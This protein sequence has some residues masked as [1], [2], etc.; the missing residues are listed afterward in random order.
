MN[1]QQQ[2]PPSDGTET[3]TVDKKTRTYD[4]RTSS[5]KDTFILE[6][7]P[8]TH[9]PTPED[10]SARARKNNSKPRR[11]NETRR[12]DPTHK[13]KTVGTHSRIQP[14]YQTRNLHSLRQAAKSQATQ[15]LNGY[16]QT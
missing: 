8:S 5:T 9:R 7:A 1:E 2:H 4:I 11:I 10:N 14:S 13:N 16:Y 15:Q 12:L 3:R 6:L